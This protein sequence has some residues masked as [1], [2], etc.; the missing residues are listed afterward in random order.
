VGDYVLNA[1]SPRQ[2]AGRALGGGL[3]TNV[4]EAVAQAKT[5]V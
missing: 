2:A 1:T 4:V 3:T 5:E